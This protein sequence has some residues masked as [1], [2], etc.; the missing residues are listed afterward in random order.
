MT[1][2]LVINSSAL[3]GLSVSRQL[4]GE[5]VEAV[6][7]AQPGVEVVERDVGAEPPP[8]LTQANV[9]ALR[10][11]EP[12]TEAE[13]ATRALS[14]Q[15]I[16]EVMAADVLVIGAPMYNLG[17]TSA[18]KTWFDHILR[19]G[20][21]FRYTATGPEGLVIGKKAVVIETRG[22]LYSEGPGSALDAQEPH[23]RGML[24]LMGVKDV[25][26]VR[27]ERLAIPDARDAAIEAA[28][29]LVRDL[30]QDQLVAA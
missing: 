18:L 20:T 7:A 24:G 12:E 22:G 1:K 11:G 28:T 8:H 5:F 25:T 9:G 17:I 23:L 15:L 19:A 4:V 21:T 26:F 29:K 16:A 10:R 13:Q 6:R 3:G 30:A 2:L 14:D 27:A